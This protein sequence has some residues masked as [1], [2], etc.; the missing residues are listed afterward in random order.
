MPFHEVLSY[1]LAALTPNPSSQES[2]D[3]VGRCGVIRV[4]FG[5][6]G[7]WFSRLSTVRVWRLRCSFQLG[8]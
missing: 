1:V 2:L 4:S 6:D 3:F 8:H 5:V 7:A